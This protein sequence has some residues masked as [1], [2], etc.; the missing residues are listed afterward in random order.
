MISMKMLIIEGRYDSLVTELSRELLQVVKD[1]WSAVAHEKGEFSGR[2]IYFKKGETVPNIDDDSEFERIYHIEVDN[3][4]IPLEF[5]VHL[6]VQW[7]E[8]FNDYRYG[9]D[10][11]NDT[12]RYSA[13]MPLIEIR[14]ELDPAEYPQV[15][16]EVAMDLRDVL[17]HE[18][19]HTTQSGW[20]TIPSKYLPSDQATRNK[21]NSGQLPTVRYYLL[22]K[23]IPSMI[24]GLYAKAKKSKQPFST[25]VN[26]YLDIWVRNGSLSDAD[27][28]KIIDTWRSYLPKLGIRQEL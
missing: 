19:E 22:K 25:V 2:K 27:K 5:Y 1:S 15:L 26:D 10:T 24:Q 12:K 9:G 11:F 23:E 16:S 3:Q 4:T 8:G 17:R 7:I 21:I 28:T 13:D 6:K 18:I 14:L 20:N